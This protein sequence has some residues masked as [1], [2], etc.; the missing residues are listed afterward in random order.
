MIGTT[1]EMEVS[2]RVFDSPFFQFDMEEQNRKRGITVNTTSPSAVP[3][4]FHFASLASKKRAQTTAEK[5]HSVAIAR[6]EGMKL[7]VINE[8]INTEKDYVNDLELITQVNES[9]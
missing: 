8:L 7:K 9:F 6:T 2:Q 1:M 3:K 5:R 4:P